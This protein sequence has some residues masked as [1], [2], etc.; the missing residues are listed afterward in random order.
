MNAV[1]D[2]STLPQEIKDEVIHQLDLRS[3]TSSL[4]ACALA[5]R[6]FLNS[7]QA[8]LFRKQCFTSS[9][10]TESPHKT[11]RML[12]LL[13]ETPHL[14][15]YVRLI[16]LTEQP[17]CLWIANDAA[18][19]AL[20]RRFT[21]IARMHVMWWE[22]YER[23]HD[24][25]AALAHVFQLPTFQHFSASQG[26]KF[27]PRLLSCMPH[28]RTLK[29][30]ETN[31]R[32]WEVPGTPAH[33]SSTLMSLELRFYGTMLADLAAE[34][35]HPACRL[36]LHN[37]RHFKC[38]IIKEPGTL[39]KIAPLIPNI[40]SLDVEI[41][42]SDTVSDAAPDYPILG[43][44]FPHL[45]H[46][47]LRSLLLE[48]LPYDTHERS[49]FSWLFQQLGHL[50]KTVTC[51]DLHFSVHI[52][53]AEDGAIWD[54]EWRSLDRLLSDS[55]PCLL[56]ARVHIVHALEHMASYRGEENAIARDVKSRL[57]LL[58]ARGILFV[59]S[60]ECSVLITARTSSHRTK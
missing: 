40:T 37:L 12:L 36:D 10:L 50:P 8:C 51:I 25:L 4:K 54:A 58:D 7:S 52:D 30:S 14:A 19:P 46:F 22:S 16:E 42:Q 31:F 18:L 21:S 6:S 28:L 45:H 27:A 60:C 23:C 39:S 15:R 35:L 55:L 17:W 20:L 33:R 26:W 38:G 32:S 53:T 29:L 3:D 41:S 2:Y 1:A 5:H 57:P 24:L 49:C 59:L 34:L 56:C 13:D 48:R 9:R 43:F 44:A 47:T 11:S